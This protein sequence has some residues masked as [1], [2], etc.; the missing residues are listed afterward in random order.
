[1]L[2]IHYEVL[3]RVLLHPQHRDRQHTRHVFSRDQHHFVEALDSPV[4]MFG[5]MHDCHSCSGIRQN[6]K[7]QDTDSIQHPL[8]PEAL[9]GCTS[10]LGTS[11][12]KHPPFSATFL[13]GLANSLFRLSSVLQALL[14]AHCSGFKAQAHGVSLRSHLIAGHCQP[15]IPP[16]CVRFAFYSC[17]SSSSRYP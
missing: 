17:S 8:T 6:G 9:P 14:V 13:P 16:R 12:P 3:V 2:V 10:N 11:S 7:T 1:M 15:H 5:L 4:Q